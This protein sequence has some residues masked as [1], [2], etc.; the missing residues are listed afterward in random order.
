MCVCYLTAGISKEYGLKGVSALSA[1]YIDCALIPFTQ[2]IT[3]GRCSRNCAASPT[4]NSD[5]QPQVYYRS[6]V[7]YSGR[8]VRVK[9]YERKWRCCIEVDLIE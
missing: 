1:H 7:C 9:E 3:H 4:L 8:K 6:Q 2:H 5:Y